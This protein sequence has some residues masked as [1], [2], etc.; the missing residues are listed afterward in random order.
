MS[1]GEPPA[2]PKPPGTESVIVRCPCCGKH[3]AVD[4]SVRNPRI[5]S[6]GEEDKE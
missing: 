6:T 4:I 2:P 3:I 1:S 5:L